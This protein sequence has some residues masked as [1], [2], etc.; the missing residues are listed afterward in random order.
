VEPA[1]PCPVYT[2]LPCPPLTA[3]RS[4]PSLP[5]SLACSAHSL[6]KAA[7]SHAL[8]HATSLHPSLYTPLLL[9]SVHPPTASQPAPQNP[10]PG[11]I[12]G[13]LRCV[14][15]ASDAARLIRLVGRAPLSLPRFAP[16]VRRG[17]HR[18]RG[19]GE[20]LLLGRADQ[21]WELSPWRLRFVRPSL[22]RCLVPLVHGAI[23]G[24][25]WAIRAC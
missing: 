13:R 12:A 11:R 23:R 24:G 16:A 21:G 6:P 25:V 4:S 8:H 7:A 3:S 14:S 15:G 22:C 9:F 10:S 1:A 5:P 19:N 2:R 17:E 20:L 18:A